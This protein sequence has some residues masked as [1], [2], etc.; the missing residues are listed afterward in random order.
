MTNVKWGKVRKLG[1]SWE[2]VPSRYPIASI[3]A[4]I[5]PKHP[6][7]QQDKEQICLPLFSV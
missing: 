2:E 7:F 4:I 1:D 6:S 3:D 5:T